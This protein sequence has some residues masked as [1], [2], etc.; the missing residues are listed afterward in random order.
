MTADEFN[1]L[2]DAAVTAHMPDFE[3]YASRAAHGLMEASIPRRSCVSISIRQHHRARAAPSRSTGLVPS[4][5]CSTPRS[6][7]SPLTSYHRDP[8]NRSEYGRCSKAQE[9]EE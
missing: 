2:F 6:T 8:Y 4:G 5:S 9:P 1:H 3:P 7:Y